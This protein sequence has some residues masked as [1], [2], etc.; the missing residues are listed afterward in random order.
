MQNAEAQDKPPKLKR[1]SRAD[2]VD[3]LETH[4]TRLSQETQ[5]YVASTQRVIEDRDAQIRRLEGRCADLERSLSELEDWMAEG[6]SVLDRI[7]RLRQDGNIDAAHHL[8]KE[9][10]REQYTIEPRPKRQRTDTGFVRRSRNGAQPVGPIPDQPVPNPCEWAQELNRKTLAGQGELQLAF[11]SPPTSGYV[12]RRDGREILLC[13]KHVCSNRLNNDEC[14]LQ[15][16][17]KP[18]SQFCVNCSNKFLAQ[19]GI[20]GQH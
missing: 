8:V 14:E 10:L 4:V 18:T 12:R 15:V 16:G 1:R 7:K 9:T 5:N 3:E 13:S 17:P 11:C 20:Q 19:I 2:L 6:R